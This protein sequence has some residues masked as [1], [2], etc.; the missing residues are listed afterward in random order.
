[1]AARGCRVMARLDSPLGPVLGQR[2]ANAL[3]KAFELRT[4]RD[5][6]T[7]YPRRLDDRGALTDISRLRVGEHATVLGRIRH[8]EQSTFKPR[9]GGRLGTRTV[10]TITDGERDITATFFNQKWRAGQLGPGTV[11]F[12]SGKV[13]LFRGRRELNTPIVEVLGN[14]VDDVDVEQ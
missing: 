13:T 7:H 2:A 14:E 5:L 10:V 8:A 9:Q 12:F 1:P 4:V 6:V 3:A 11:A